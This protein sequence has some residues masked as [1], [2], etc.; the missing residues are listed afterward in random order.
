MN[1]RILVVDDEAIVAHDI[2]EC[3]SHLGCEIVGTALSG[4][5]AIEKAGRFR[6]DLIMMDIVLQGPMDGVEAATHIREH[7]DIPC[8]FLSAYSDPAVLA[9]AK[10][11]SPAGY[12]VKPF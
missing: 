3:L 1:R 4:P 12:L 11:A 9:R 6:P 10:I 2:S 5:D 8:V 7:Y